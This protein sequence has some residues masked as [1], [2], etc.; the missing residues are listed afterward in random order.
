MCSGEIIAFFFLPWV[1]CE[2]SEEIV[3]MYIRNIAPDWAIIFFTSLLNFIPSGRESLRI[4][5]TIEAGRILSARVS[6][7]GSIFWLG[8][9]CWK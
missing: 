6:E 4:L 9:L 5:V 8:N 3:E 2:I 1:S 7:F